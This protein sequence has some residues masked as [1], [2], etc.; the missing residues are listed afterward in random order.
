MQRSKVRAAICGDENTRYFHACAN[1]RRRMNRI[2]VIEHDGRE[3][4]NHNQKADI[5]HA[6]YHNLVGCVRETNWTFQLSSLYPGGPLPLDELGSPFTSAEIRKA[7]HSMRS[8]ASPGPDGFG[9]SFFK[10]TWSVSFASMID[11]FQGFHD[12]TAD[13]E[14]INRSYLILLPKKNNAR[15][16]GDFR[17]S[18]LQNTTIKSLSKVLTN[19]L[20]PVIP[21]L[22]SS[23][24]AGF[25]LGRCI[26]ESFAYATN[27]LHCCYRRNAPTL[28]LKLDFHKAFDRVN[29]DSLILSACVA[30]FTPCLLPV[31]RRSS[32]MGYLGDGSIAEMGFAREILYPRISSLLLWMFSVV[33]SITLPLPLLGILNIIT[34]SRLSSLNLVTVPKIPNLSLTPLKPSCHPQHG[35]RD[36]VLKYAIALLNK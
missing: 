17:P 5:L 23:D 3:Y 18:A 32:L 34:K 26:A 15:E 6:F 25:I 13:L 16:V 22:V 21:L 2:Q 8:T 33:C 31:K 36:A 7:V 35:M 1:Q 10:A 9:P 28:I 19:R 4:H 12:H 29:L 20:R 27:L 14:P 24:Q 30:G 11:L